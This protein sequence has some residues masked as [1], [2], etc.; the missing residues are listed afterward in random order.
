MQVSLKYAPKL[1]K[2]R[3]NIY[4][5]QIFS[6]LKV[7]QYYYIIVKDKNKSEDFDDKSKNELK[8]LNYM[9][10]YKDEENYDQF[11]YENME[12]IDILSNKDEANKVGN[13]N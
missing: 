3:E 13:D 5:I 12:W 1:W 2:I 6:K 4:E 9:F 8:K 10:I 7:N 11:K